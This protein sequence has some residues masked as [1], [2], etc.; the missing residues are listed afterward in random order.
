MLAEETPNNEINNKKC[1]N[2]GKVFRAPVNLQAHKN[3]KTPCVIREI[4]PEN[5]NNPLRCIFCNKISSNKSNLLKHHK[6]CKIKNGGMDI[7]DDKVRHE[8][9]I[10]IL[11]EQRE[12]DIENHD[13]EINELREQFNRLA[14]QLKTKPEVT[15]QIVN[16]GTVNITNNFYNYDK[17]FVETIKLTEDDLLVTSIIKKMLE[18][19]YFN[20]NLPQNHTLYLP[21]IKEDRLLIYKNGSW[22]NIS[23]VNLKGVMNNVRVNA[24]NIGYNKINHNGLFNDDSFEKLCP[25]VRE[26]IKSFNNGEVHS[27][28]SD[29]DVMD[30]IKSHRHL[31]SETL[32]R[33]KIV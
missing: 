10:R 32:K 27:E 33:T 15:N 12:K 25:V 7:L 22:Q 20:K 14:E 31:I 18:L 28:I 13:R 8:Q 30:M 11:K 29:D 6:V 2:C 3:R 26:A 21:N 16:N 19:V 4:G 5:I 17:P 24:Y 1:Y 9:E 23:G